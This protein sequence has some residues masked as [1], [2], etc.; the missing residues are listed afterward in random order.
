MH[1]AALRLEL[2]DPVV[3]P[4]DV[5]AADDEE[6]VRS[7]HQL[8]EAR[9]GSA[10]VHLVEHRGRER[11]GVGEQHHL[12][13]TREEV[14]VPALDP[15]DVRE[16]PA[17]PRRV[18][19]PADLGVR[20]PVLGIPDGVEALGERSGERR[21][22]RRLRSE[23][24]HA[25]H[26]ARHGRGAYDS[27]RRRVRPSEVRAGRSSSIGHR[28]RPTA[29]PGDRRG[30]RHLRAGRGREQRCRTT[31]GAAWGRGSRRPRRP[32]DARP[33]GRPAAPRLRAGAR[34]G[35]RQRGRGGR[36]RI[37]GRGRRAAPRA[38]RTLPRAR[39]RA[40]RAGPRRRRAR[41]RPRARRPGDPP[42]GR[43]CCGRRAGAARPRARA[44]PG[45]AGGQARGCRARRCVARRRG[46]ARA[47]RHRRGARQR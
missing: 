43:G 7:P 45:R 16:L 2:A 21:L 8:V 34:G 27:S 1:P 30:R 29:E 47:G 19:G 46:G 37:G 12:R 14:L 31:R 10:E 17:R 33:R 40:R 20:A 3:A 22:A 13:E 18:R 42:A 39:A 38:R 44:A 32:L 6:V 25:L 36:A 4:R 26:V 9:R 35:C 28:D 5:E 24:A 41:A 11:V 23:E 15:R